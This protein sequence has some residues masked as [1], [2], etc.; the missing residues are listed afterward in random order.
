[1]KQYCCGLLAVSLVL[2]MASHGQGQPMYAFTTLDVPGSLLPTLISPSRIN[3]SGQIVGSY[4]DATGQH[5]FLFDQ[6]HY[7]QVNETVPSASTIVQS[8]TSANVFLVQF[9]DPGS[10]GGIP[11]NPSIGAVKLCC[12]TSSPSSGNLRLVSSGFADSRMAI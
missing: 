8:G 11:A 3:A 6:T 2:G 5:G 4:R 10:V 1:M 7:T 12:M 9:T